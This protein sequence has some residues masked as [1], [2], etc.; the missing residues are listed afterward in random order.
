MKQKMVYLNLK[1][2]NV[3]VLQEEC[4]REFVAAEDFEE[5]DVSDMEVSS[6]VFYIRCLNNL[7]MKLKVYFTIS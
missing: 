2:L 1:I 4:E 7:L 6:M 5:S 3:S